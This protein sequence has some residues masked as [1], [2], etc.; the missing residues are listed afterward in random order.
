MNKFISASVEH[1]KIGIKTPLSVFTLYRF[2][3][4]AVMIEYYELPLDLWSI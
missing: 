2:D 4:I 3:L 1:K